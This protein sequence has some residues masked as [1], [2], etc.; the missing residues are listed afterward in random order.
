VSLAEPDV[1]QALICDDVSGLELDG[2]EA[3]VPA[4]AE[5]VV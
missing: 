4:G 1:R 5:P 3:D 2:F